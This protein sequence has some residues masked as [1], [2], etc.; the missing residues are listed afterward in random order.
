MFFRFFLIRFTVL[1]KIII[2][3][4]WAF[5]LLNSALLLWLGHSYKLCGCNFGLNWLK[6]YIIFHVTWFYVL[7]FC[8]TLTYNINFLTSLFF[9]SFFKDSRKIKTH[10]N[11]RSRRRDSRFFRITILWFNILKNYSRRKFI[12][13]CLNNLLNFAVMAL[14]VIIITFNWFLSTTVFYL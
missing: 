2:H 14:N 11:L 8:R 3:L 10:S 6:F 1:N 5:L 9:L 12:T 4:F 7:L 13:I